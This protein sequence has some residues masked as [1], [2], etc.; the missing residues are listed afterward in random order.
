MKQVVFFSN[1]VGGAATYQAQ[2]LDYLLAHEYQ[3]V[4][5]D[6]DPEPTLSKMRF[7]DLTNLEVVKIPLW[8][9]PHSARNHIVSF[10]QGERIVAL[11][12]PALLVKYYDILVIPNKDRRIFVGM[13]LHSGMLKMTLRR[14]LVEW[15]ASFASLYVSDLVYVSQ[16]TRSYWERRYPWMRSCNKRVVYNG[17][18][19]LD[20]V[21]PRTL[22][23]SIRVG[24]VGRLLDEKDPILFCETAR[25]A[26]QKGLN[27]VFHV[28]GDGALLDRIQLE[29]SADVV[30]HP[31]S[32]ESEIYSSIDVL[33]MTSPIE[34]C[35]YVLLE[36]KSH[37]I[38]AISASV[39]GIPE[40]V[41]NGTDGII[42]TH[43]TPAAFYNAIHVIQSQ[44]TLYSKGC[45]QT[46]D[47]FDAKRQSQL[48]WLTRDV[49]T[50]TAK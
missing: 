14:L 23:D 28:F 32:S 20:D 9:N 22:P 10:L 40:I 16:F 29:Y 50:V 45:L 3:V 19:I 25:L 42:T 2:Q 5:I 35:P 47:L 24:F 37:A 17:V 30:L 6:E 39:G 41:K 44:Y 13:T 4:L 27:A 7:S 11:S 38:P 33:L 8:S 26:R 48:T 15:L 18:N 43:R 49:S 31:W 36:A 21:E 46:R 34:N 12:N 1:A